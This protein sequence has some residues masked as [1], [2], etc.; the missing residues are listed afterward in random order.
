MAAFLT[1][2]VQAAARVAPLCPYPLI[3]SAGGSAFFDIVVEV[4]TP[5]ARANGWRV[6]LRSGAVVSHDDGDVRADDA[7]QPGARGGLAGG[8]AGGLGPGAVHARAG[9]GHPGR[10]QARPALRPRP[11]GADRGPGGDGALR[12]LPGARIERLNDQHAYLRG[13]EVAPG[14]LVQ[15]G[16]SH[17]CTAFD[18]WRVIPVVDDDYRVVD[19]L[20]TYF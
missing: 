1:T 16:I 15:L 6:V 7:V 12:T 2:M 10:R 17:P 19:L 5:P 8:G 20:H 3:L 4:L 9:P 11:A 13:A 14:E 18:K